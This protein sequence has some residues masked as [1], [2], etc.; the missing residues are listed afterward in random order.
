M[1]SNSS[2]SMARR[3]LR[4]AVQ[5]IRDLG[6]TR[7]TVTYPAKLHAYQHLCIAFT[8]AGIMGGV[9]YCVEHKGQR[10]AIPFLGSEPRAHLVINHE[11]DC[12]IAYDPATDRFT[13]WCDCA[14]GLH[15]PVRI[16]KA[17]A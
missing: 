10:A 8:E 13:R 14:F 5:W 17:A 11:G 15:L 4:R 2:T 1:T 7:M 16:M 12:P 9:A 3:P 6:G